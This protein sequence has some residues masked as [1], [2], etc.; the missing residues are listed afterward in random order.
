[1]ELTFCGGKKKKDYVPDGCW[2]QSSAHQRKRYRARDPRA[3][4]YVL[5]HC[6]YMYMY[7][8]IYILMHTCIYVYMYGYV[9]LCIHAY[10]R[11]ST[12][13]VWRMISASKHVCAYTY[14]YVYTYMYTYVYTCVCVYVYMHICALRRKRYGP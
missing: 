11:T 6:V 7:V 1:M 8:F 12:K 10:I 9:Y 2:Q 3:G 14:M 5:I 13:R 4:A